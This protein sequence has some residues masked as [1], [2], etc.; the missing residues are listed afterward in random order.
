MRILDLGTF[1]AFDL[2]TTGL[3][4]S[5][6]KIT[7]FAA[8]RF[9]NGEM[10]EHYSTLVN[11]GI[12]IPATIT[13]ITGITDEMVAEAPAEEAVIDSM[14]AFIGKDPLVAHNIDFD[15]RF[16]THLKSM[17]KGGNGRLENPLYDTLALAQSFLFFLSS[18]RLGTVAESLRF[19]RD[20]EHR[21]LVDAINV[22]RIF[23]RLLE[24]ACSYP[25]SVIQR[26][27]AVIGPFSVPNKALY[28]NLANYLVRESLSDRGLLRSKISVPLKSNVFRHTGRR[29]KLPAS[30][31]EVFGDK[32]LFA[33]SMKKEDVHPGGFEVR[34]SQIAYSDF[35]SEVFS[36]GAI[37]ISE[38]GTGFG[39]SL[40][41]LFPTLRRAFET[42]GGSMVI[43][44]YTKHL[45]DQLFYQEVPKV[46]RALDVSFVATLLKGR[47]DYLCKTRLDRVIEDARI[48]LTPYD[49]QS[50][51]PVIVWLSRT[52]TG[53]FDECPGFLNRRSPRVRNLI[54]SEPGFCTTDTC[55]KHAGCFVASLRRASQQADLVVVNHSLLLS[56]LSNPGVLPPFSGAVID[57]AH[58]FVKVAYDRFKITIHHFAIRDK[59]MPADPNSKRSRR[60]KRQLDA[61]GQIDPGLIKRFAGVQTCVGRILEA[62][63]RFF[64]ELS[65]E[66][67]DGYEAGLP[68]VQRR[69]YKN[70]KEH[71]GN[72]GKSLADL[73]KSLQD[74]FR[75]VEGLAKALRALPEKSVDTETVVTLERLSEA[76]SEILTAVQVTTGLEKTDWVYWEEGW[77]SDG[78][79]LIS[80]NGVPID[81]GTDLVEVVF[82]PLHAVLVT[83]ATLRIGGGFDYL[84]SRLHLSHYSEKPIYT[85]TFPSPFRYDEQCRYYQW[86]GKISPDSPDFPLLLSRLIEHAHSR[87]KKRTMVLFTSRSSLENCYEELRSMGLLVKMD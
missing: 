57:E 59:L 71:F 27:V 17:Y 50:L 15:L 3:A 48:L 20:G 9:R 1:V 25:L 2:E 70:L 19:K 16:L 64:G 67:G 87:W 6:D 38:A 75:G 32:G 46:A 42:D 74:G 11:P 73:G 14:L 69:R 4:P 7:E 12:P 79:L 65:R 18:H 53:D 23:V 62:S 29:R 58:N 66:H 60:L 78:Q 5:K 56:E 24:E 52:K 43:A 22:G 45:Q 33:Q 72:L 34:P 13:S 10:D 44:C 76:I 83:S 55:R 68:Y 77:F 21:A 47:Q 36:Q 31:K 84:M 26:I 81:V 39:K 8:V 35:V 30:G 41:Y 80:L 49:A 63:D 40:A 54:Q 61:A 37:G 86:A 82:S 85:D 51:I 28:M